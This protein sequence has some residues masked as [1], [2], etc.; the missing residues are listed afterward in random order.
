M[1]FFVG[2][3]LPKIVKVNA[4][5]HVSLF[6]RAKVKFIIGG[7]GL[8]LAGALELP[9]N[10]SGR[11]MFLNLTVRVQFSVFPLRF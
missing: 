6:R 10:G 5:S 1:L 7:K 8:A 3:F 2:F 9:A 11:S 4:V